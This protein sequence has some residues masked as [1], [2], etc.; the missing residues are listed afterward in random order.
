MGEDGLKGM[1]GLA[2]RARQLVPG[3][4]MSLQ[5]IRDGKAALVI[6]DDKASA[7]T[8]KKLQDAC[9]HRDVPVFV[10]G[11]GMLGASCGRQGMA[12][13]A[14]KAGKISQNV[15]KQCEHQ[16]AVHLPGQVMIAEDKG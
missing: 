15:L 8:A 14:L 3:A 1:L 13:A 10:L 7:N 5:L 4:E 11:N 9:R 16:D 6:I 2:F 12:A